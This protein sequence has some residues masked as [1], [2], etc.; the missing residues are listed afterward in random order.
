LLFDSCFYLSSGRKDKKLILEEMVKKEGKTNINS[1]GE[2]ITVCYVSKNNILGKRSDRVE[3][4]RYKNAKKE[5]NI[6]IVEK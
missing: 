1:G 3:V 4:R 6:I 5:N 2:N